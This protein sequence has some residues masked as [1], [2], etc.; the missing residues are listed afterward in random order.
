M[1]PV[2]YCL[3]LKAI[4]GRSMALIALPLLAT[5]SDQ[6]VKQSSL[7]T[8]CRLLLL[9]TVINLFSMQPSSSGR[10][11]RA[12]ALARHGELEA[13]LQLASRTFVR[14][15]FL[16]QAVLLA[17]RHFLDFN[18]VVD[19]FPMH[20]HILRRIDPN[21]HLV[22][23]HSHHRDGDLRPDHQRLANLPCEYEQETTP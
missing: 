10:A 13:R 2:F 3:A 17:L 5:L 21:S 11:V 8:P 15:D 12:P 22:S 6:P 23:V 20:R 9:N 1:D 19:L 18:S 16:S 7:V 14:C 4:P